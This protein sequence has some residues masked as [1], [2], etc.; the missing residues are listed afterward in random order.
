MS[1]HNAM[2]RPPRLSQ[3]DVAELDDEAV[4]CS[5]RES[6][7]ALAE[8][9]RMP[10]RSAPSLLEDSD[11][12]SSAGVGGNVAR[13]SARP[14]YVARGEI[15]T[16]E[17]RTLAGSGTS[18][19]HSVRPSV[20]ASRH[21]AVP[22]LASAE[23]ELEPEYAYENDAQLLGMT[24]EEPLELVDHT[25]MMPASQPP[26][27]VQP[28]VRGRAPLSSLPASGGAYHSQRM[29]VP[30][31]A[32]SWRESPWVMP[33]VRQAAMTPPVA[34]RREWNVLQTIGIVGTGIIMLAIVFG[35]V[36]FANSDGEERSMQF[37][38]RAAAAQQLPAP[39]ATTLPAAATPTTFA[40]PAAAPDAAKG[41][42]IAVSTTV[43]PSPV[44]VE[45]KPV[46][47][48][49]RVTTTA[50]AKEP[51]A[52]RAPLPAAPRAKEARETK[53]EASKKTREEQEVE[54]LLA[55]LGEAQLR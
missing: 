21:S 28:S 25:V 29:S 53:P 24:R 39:A 17:T 19:T 52:Q 43:A 7:V 32:D 6:R 41:R 11:V 55:K 40:M 45:P 10:R 12:V 51:V 13:F 46:T 1:R 33:S 3:V 9:P 4:T 16:G 42:V 54:S 2:H 31:P 27:A 26:P 14:S 49:P 23:V 50:R 35:A 20:R 47:P 22:M 8:L 44:V 15:Q 34:P 48:T 37:T 36:M 5:A 18:P 38:Q 30:P